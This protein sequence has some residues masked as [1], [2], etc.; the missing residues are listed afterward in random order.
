MRKIVGVIISLCALAGCSH[1][2]IGTLPQIDDPDNAA[3]ITVVRISSLSGKMASFKIWLDGAELIAI[4]NGEY[5]KFQIGE[6]KHTIGVAAPNYNP[7]VIRIYCDPKE[8]YFFIVSP[9][10]SKGAD[11]KRVT[12]EEAKIKIA[13]SKYLQLE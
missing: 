1:G 8:Q 9:S 3:E 13:Q 10:M 11:I 4:R 12:E 2:L 6:G 7:Q 5:T